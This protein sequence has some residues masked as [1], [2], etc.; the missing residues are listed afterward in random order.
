MS[1]D[2]YPL[3]KQLDDAKADRAFV[4]R[5]RNGLLDAAKALVKLL[6][7]T[8]AETGWRDRLQTD[9]VFAWYEFDQLRQAI[10]EAEESPLGRAVRIARGNDGPPTVPIHFAGPSQEEIDRLRRHDLRAVS[11]ITRK[12]GR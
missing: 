3:E 12:R 2:D 6:E 8:G 7:D 9:R 10:V 5:Q 4:Q 11:A 1:T